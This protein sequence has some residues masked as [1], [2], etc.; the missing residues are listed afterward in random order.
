LDAALLALTDDPKA[1]MIDI[2]QRA[3]VGR[4][5]VYGH[6][7]SRDELIE[8]ALARSIHRSE[9]ELASVDLS[10][11]AIEA[12]ERLVRHSWRIVDRFH[13]VLG[14]VEQT[15]SNSE[16]LEHHEQPMARVRA[17]LV[18]GQA[19]GSIRSDL[20]PDWLT[21]CFTSILHG[22]AGELR[23]GRLSEAD[24]DG[25][26]VRTVLSLMAAPSHRS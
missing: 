15:L 24:A 16:I 13:R 5:T 6:F 25:V 10:G 12:L 14:A 19:E 7:S 17:L 20:D 8:T 9:A 3:G 2:A 26:V 11:D 4:V 21:T 18:R 23:A 1:S 22:A